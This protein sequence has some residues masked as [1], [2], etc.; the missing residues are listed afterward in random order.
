MQQ[1]YTR[2][3]DPGQGGFPVQPYSSGLTAPAAVISEQYGKIMIVSG[4]AEEKPFELGNKHLFMVITSADPLPLRRGRGAQAE[5]SRRPR[6]PWSIPTTR[7]R[8]RCW[9]RR[10]PAG[11]GGRPRRRDGRILRAVDHRFRP[12]RQQDHLVERR[13]VPRRR[14]LFR[15]RHAGAPDVRPEGQH[16]MG[17][18]P[19]GAGRRQVRRARARPPWASPCRRNGRSQ[20]TYKPQFGPTTAEFAKAYQAKFNAKADYH[21]ASGYTSG[22]ILQHAIEQGRLASIRRKCTAALNAIDV[23]T[24]FGHIKFATDPGHHGLQIGARDGAGAVANG[25]RQARA[26]KWSGRRRRNPPI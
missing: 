5:E 11:Q 1:L 8:R 6:S 17:V 12:D 2:L 13:R 26:G 23:T 24:F 7:S 25:R 4:G 22:V 9:P 20:V 21:S 18:D 10:A 16:E 15:R 3:V 19:G 14:P